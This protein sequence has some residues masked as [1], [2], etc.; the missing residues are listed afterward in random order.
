MTWKH[1][2]FALAAV[3]CVQTWRSCNRE[4]PPP[5]PPEREAC[6]KLV[7]Q[8][9]WDDPSPPPPDDEPEP[10]PPATGGPSFNGI[11]LPAWTAY[12][13]PQP[14]EDLRSYRDRM[15]PL[16]QAALAPQR[17]RVARSRDDFAAV[18]HLDSQQKAL[19]DTQRQ[20][21]ADRIEEKL[22][23]GFLNGDFD[24]HTFKP[25]AGVSLA[26]DVLDIVDDA[27]Q[28]FTASLREDQKAA[29]AQHPFDFADYLLFGTRWED[30]L[31]Q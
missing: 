8:H 4:V 11:Q 24:P 7:A 25:M 6:M 21:A 20:Q 17:A 18:A 22:L 15:L 29:L 1:V 13:A 10:P 9:T 12:F 23:G 28:T 31:P 14:G 3:L 26:R 2:S 5:A 30:A 16:A 19:L 27:N